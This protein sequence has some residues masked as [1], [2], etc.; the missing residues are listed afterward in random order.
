MEIQQ[1]QEYEFESSLEPAEFV[2]R[3]VRPLKES[4]E[5]EGVGQLLNEDGKEPGTPDG[6]FVLSFRIS[7][8]RRL[9]KLIDAQVQEV[10]GSAETSTEGK[11]QE[12]G[13]SMTDDATPHARKFY[14]RIAHVYDALA[15]SSEHHAR[16]EGLRL[17]AVQPGE[18]VLEI[19][20]G[21]GHT[22]VTLAETVGADGTVAGVDISQGMCDVAAKRLA[23]AGF[24][25]NVRL[26]VAEVP[27][28]PFEDNAFNAV[29]CSFTLELFPLDVIP[30]VVDEVKR[31]LIPGGRFGAVS[32]AVTPDGGKDS[33][34]EKT[35]KWMHHHF[36]HI[37]D[38][39]PIDAAKFFEDGGLEITAREDIVMWTMP[40]IALV[41][42]TSA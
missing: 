11:V 8:A 9:Q 23:E 31:V 29:T 1:F 10:C 3:F 18:R 16:E 6:V 32:M 30:S 27:P 20:F 38:C 34:L 37:V 28:L 4:A 41:G 33:V 7:D 22:L 17:L 12:M 25:E 14:D 24:E 5:R 35:Y 21:T 13:S 26:E 2:E 40:V 15:D 36:P 39:Q 19:G 42:T